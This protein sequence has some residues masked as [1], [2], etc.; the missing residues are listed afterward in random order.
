MQVESPS[1]ATD[2][3]ASPLPRKKPGPKPK[4]AADAK[5]ARE[6]SKPSWERP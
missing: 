4:A 1:V 2:I 3:A 6:A 5:H